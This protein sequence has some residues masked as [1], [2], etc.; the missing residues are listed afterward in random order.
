VRCGATPVR[1]PRALRKA[2]RARSTAMSTFRWWLRPGVGKS[3]FA[4]TASR[5]AAQPNRTL[6]RA[7]CNAATYA[8]AR[9]WSRW[10]IAIE[11]WAEAGVRFVRR[12]RLRSRL[13]SRRSAS[14][15]S[16][17]LASSR[18]CTPSASASA[19]TVRVDGA[20]RP[21]SRR[22]IVKACTP[23]RRASSAWDKKCSRR[24]RRN[25]SLNA[26]RSHAVKDG[27]TKMRGHCCIKVRA[28][29]VA[30]RSSRTR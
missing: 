19:R 12:Q 24:R 5:V 29:L 2:Q 15:T 11:V 4:S 23:D 22:V 7:G 14:A 20:V 6:H 17:G 8:E 27:C 21:L 18:G 1:G 26:I 30:D 10:A 13:R 25:V 16:S 3:A 28:M 9:C